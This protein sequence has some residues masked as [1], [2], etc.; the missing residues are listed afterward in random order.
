MPVTLPTMSFFEEA[1]RVIHED[2]TKA[3][4]NKGMYI[5]LC[6]GDCAFVFY[7]IICMYMH[8]L[9]L[10]SRVGMGRKVLSEEEV[11]KTRCR[12]PIPT[13]SIFQ[14]AKRAINT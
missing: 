14:E 6:R 7:H 8:S 9:I 13:M 11:W 10:Y 12:R 4:V 2:V 5:I 3:Q 1:K